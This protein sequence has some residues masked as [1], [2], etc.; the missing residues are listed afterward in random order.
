MAETKTVAADNG[1]DVS[2]ISH[3]SISSNDGTAEDIF[4]ETQEPHHRTILGGNATSST[5]VSLHRCSL[6]DCC[7]NK[8]HCPFCDVRQ[9]KPTQPGRVRDHLHLTH[10]QH[11]VYYDGMMIV[12][13]FHT[14]RGSSTKGGHYHC[15]VCSTTLLKRN[16]FT[17]H[18]L[19]HASKQGLDSSAVHA[20]DSK[21]PSVIYYDDHR[22]E[23]CHRQCASALEPHFHCPLCHR[24][25]A[26]LS[27][28]TAHL[29][30]CEKRA[31]GL[32]A[33]ADL[34]GYSL[35][36]PKLFSPHMVHG[37]PRLKDL[38]QYKSTP[39]WSATCPVS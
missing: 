12:K 27:A 14:C 31:S 35:N 37:M 25:C 39:S 18:L 26:Q 9:Y 36:V 10:F 38:P 4:K 11:A 21:K 7:D 16:A 19:S 1:K 34:A 6:K 20:P 8:V 23:L 17:S 3:S 24:S 13:C 22:I 2:M 15:P 32:A 28:L 5:T 29:W 33:K 30:R